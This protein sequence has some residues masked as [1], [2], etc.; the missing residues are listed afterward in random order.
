MTTY[1]IQC[2]GMIAEWAGGNHRVIDLPE[3]TDVLTLRKAAEQHWPRL[4]GITYRVAV[5]QRL[6]EDSTPVNHNDEI[7]L[8][9]P[10]AG[11]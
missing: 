7:A 1:N 3:E 2:F 9:P 4:A 11:G 8:M 10:F 5:N 6:A